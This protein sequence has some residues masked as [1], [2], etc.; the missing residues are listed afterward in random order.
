M[1][2]ITIL[3]ICILSFSVNCFAQSDNARINELEKKVIELEERFSQMELLLVA[4]A[5]AS[6][7][8]AT[9]EE[10]ESLESLKSKWRKLETDM[11]PS[12]VREILGEPD[13]IN[14]GQIARWHYPR[15][16]NVTFM[17][18]KLSQW[19]EPNF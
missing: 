17:R 8:E 5:M 11:K 18:N 15:G 6:E 4:A 14:G 9:P 3:T 12:K 13:T 19:T 10:T 7:N 2:H 16:G 1:K